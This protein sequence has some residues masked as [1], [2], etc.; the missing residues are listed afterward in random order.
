MF[1]KIRHA[2]WFIPILVILVVG[3]I[4]GTAL[5][6][7]Y[8]LDKTI[9]ATVTVVEPLPPPCTQ[10]TLYTNL[11][12]T[13]EYVPP[14]AYGTL[15]VGGSPVTKILYFKSNVDS[16]GNPYPAGEIKPSTIVVTSTINPAVAT[17]M[18]IVGTPFGA[19]NGNHP[20]MLTL[21]V[22]PVG[23]G[24]SNFNIHVTGASQ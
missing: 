20:C 1:N 12:C 10:V 8:C 6:V 18:S 24:T 15:T 21:S 22:L 9:P 3:L 2:K 17:L 16:M 19:V 23:A 13:V 4:T 14:L 5:A 11:D 7:T